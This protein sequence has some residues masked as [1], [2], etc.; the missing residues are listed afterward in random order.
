[1]RP[2]FFQHRHVDRNALRRVQ[3]DHADGSSGSQHGFRGAGIDENI[4]LGRRAI[5]LHHSAI[6]QIPGHVNSS[7]HDHKLADVA[8][9]ARG[10]R[11]R[12]RKIRQRTCGED[13]YGM[14]RVGK[15]LRQILCRA[16]RLNRACCSGKRDAGKF[17]RNAAPLGGKFRVSGERRVAAKEDRHIVASGQFKET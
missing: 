15:P 6:A 8:R 3:R 14:R 7:A 16:L 10:A 11:E 2:E 9:G 4:P 13:L 1:M 5:R 17:V 12:L